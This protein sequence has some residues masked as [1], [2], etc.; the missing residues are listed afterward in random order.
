MN[1]TEP[2]FLEICRQQEELDLSVK[3]FCS[4]EGIKE[5]TFYYWR[6]NLDIPEQ[7][8]LLPKQKK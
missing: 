3:D 5:S 4:D 6:N 7:I 1:L 8:A 2:K